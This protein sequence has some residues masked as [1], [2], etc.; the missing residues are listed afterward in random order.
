MVSTEPDHQ[1]ECSAAEPVPFEGQS[2]THQAY[3]APSAE[4]W[5]Q[6]QSMD[7]SSKQEASHALHF[8]GTSFL[9]RTHY[10]P[11]PPDALQSP[12]TSLVTDK[13]M[14]K[15][16][17]LQ[18]AKF[19]GQSTMHRDFQ[20]PVL[21]QLLLPRSTASH[22]TSPPIRFEGESSMKAHYPAHPVEPP[23]AAAG[24]LDHQ[25]NCSAAKPLPFEGQST[26]HNAYQARP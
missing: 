1:V 3:Q 2:T 19:E 21:E 22:D 15:S 9:M 10:Q 6:G 7:R 4:F 5:R 18:L 13:A 11:P 14:A 25:V 20:A 26:T 23:Q 8:E 24:K 16:T 17:P 12:A